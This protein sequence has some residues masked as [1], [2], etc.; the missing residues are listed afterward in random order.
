MPHR[1]SGFGAPMLALSFPT[2]VSGALRFPRQAAGPPLP[3]ASRQP[4]I[5][6]SV[7]RPDGFASEVLVQCLA[8]QQASAAACLCLSPPSR[9][10]PRRPAGRVPAMAVPCPVRQQPP[11]SPDS[12][13]GSPPT[14]ARP[15][16]LPCL[17]RALCPWSPCALSLLRVWVPWPRGSCL[18]PCPG[19]E[20]FV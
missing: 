13:S 12:G 9:W 14:P 18:G 1:R 4:S 17:V 8:G 10:L 7:S 19:P 2:S 16:G 20:P 6:G 5:P 15:S 3:R 11:L